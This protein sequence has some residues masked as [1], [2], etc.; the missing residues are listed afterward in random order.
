MRRVKNSFLLFALSFSVVAC[1]QVPVVA[2]PTSIATETFTPYVGGT[3]TA[4][5]S[6]TPTP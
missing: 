1:S 4:L 2:T 3:E 5:A 6:I